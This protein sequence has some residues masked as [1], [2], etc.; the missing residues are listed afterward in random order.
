MYVYLNRETWL[1]VYVDIQKDYIVSWKFSENQ[2]LNNGKKIKEFREA[3]DIDFKPLEEQ[4]TQIGK[5]E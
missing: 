3:Q 5:D 2:I 4:W 1:G